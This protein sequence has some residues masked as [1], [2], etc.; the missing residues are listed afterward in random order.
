MFDRRI[1]GIAMALV[2]GCGYSSAEL[3]NAKGYVQQALEHW[4]QGGKPA[5]LASRTPPIEFHEALWNSGEKLVKF[6]IGAV[7]YVS[8][9][10]VVRCET[11][12]TVR[13]RKGKERTE[14]VMFDVVSMVPNVKVVNN[15]MP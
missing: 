9:D 11:R 8:K 14:T 15:P 4:Q 6:D 12:L 7:R 5:E 1:V 3:D 2:S 13:N 10:Q